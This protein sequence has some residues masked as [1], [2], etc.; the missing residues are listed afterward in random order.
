MS[1]KKSIKAK[2]YNINKQGDE[3]TYNILA[4]TKKPVVYKLDS[5]FRYIYL[6]FKVHQKHIAIKRFL[7]IYDASRKLIFSSRRIIYLM[8]KN[9]PFKSSSV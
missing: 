4:L 6:P 7:F 2:R 1:K 9:F 8:F 5:V 3:I